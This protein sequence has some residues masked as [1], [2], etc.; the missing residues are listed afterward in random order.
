MNHP[1][2]LDE[3]KSKIL[4][5]VIV[6]GDLK[7]LTPEERTKYV[8]AVCDSVGLNPLTKPFELITLNGKL[9]LYAT[10]TAT[11]Q[12]RS[13]KKVSIVIK[14]R[15]VI[16]DTYVVTAAATMGD[17]TDESTGAVYIGGLKG[18]YLANAMMKCET[19][20]KRRVTLS[21]CGL[22]LLDESEVETIPGD[23]KEAIDVSHGLQL[24]I[25][26]PK[27]DPKAS[28]EDRAELTAYCDTNHIDP[29]VVKEI[30]KHDY[31]VDSSKD[32]VKSQ[33]SE[34][35]QKLKTN[36]PHQRPHN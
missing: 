3:E 31:K 25:P 11:D 6:S 16:N 17:R 21:I 5:K 19:K 7:S 12:L 23:K 4:E 10:R 13:I 36:H 34:I 2:P 29:K 26:Q 24:E 33:V 9:T 15:E 28:L 30:I 35:L 22:G 20:A 14:S 18:D 27:I 8:F 32:L 1:A